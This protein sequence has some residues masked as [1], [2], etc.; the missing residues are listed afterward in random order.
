MPPFSETLLDRPLLSQ[1]LAG[2]LGQ[3]PLVPPREVGRELEELLARPARQRSKLWE[4]V[5]HAAMLQVKR[6]CRQASKEFVP[7][8][9]AGLAPFC[10]ALKSRAFAVE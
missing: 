4:F 10:D 7:L 2:A 5:S 3:Q 8:R 6:L 1:A 9:T